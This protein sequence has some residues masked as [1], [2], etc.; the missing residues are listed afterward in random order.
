MA[1]GGDRRDAFRGNPEAREAQ[2]GPL[3]PPEGRAGTAH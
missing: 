3:T 1:A 2:F